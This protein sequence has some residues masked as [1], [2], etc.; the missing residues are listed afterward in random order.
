MISNL[1]LHIKYEFHL[2]LSYPIFQQYY[3]DPT[4]LRPHRKGFQ[5]CICLLTKIREMPFQMPR[6]PNRSP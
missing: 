1:F 5:L 6:N 4:H 3:V 2:Q